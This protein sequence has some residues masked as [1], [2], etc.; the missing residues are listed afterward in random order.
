MLTPLV[1]ICIPS[2]NSEKYILETVP[3]AIYDVLR[4]GLECDDLKGVVIDPFD[5]A[6]TLTKDILSSF[7]NDYEAWAKEN[8]IVSPGKSSMYYKEE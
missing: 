1:S 8:G 5:R 6:F 4:Q 7:L 2:Y 3:V